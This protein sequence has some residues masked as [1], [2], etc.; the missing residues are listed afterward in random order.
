LQVSRVR[1]KAQLKGTGQLLRAAFKGV[2]LAALQF[3]NAFGI[4][5]KTYGAALSTELNGQWQAHIAQPND[6]DG[7]LVVGVHTRWIHELKN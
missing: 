1:A 2:V 6:G 4:D 3:C 7:F 5:V